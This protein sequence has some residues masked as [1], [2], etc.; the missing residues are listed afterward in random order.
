MC[1]L[2]PP[3]PAPHPP[4][5]LPTSSTKGFKPRVASFWEEKLE[6][7]PSI[8]SVAYVS[9]RGT[10]AESSPARKWRTE[11]E[12]FGNSDWTVRDGPSANKLLSTGEAGWSGLPPHTLQYSKMAHRMNTGLIVGYLRFKFIYMS[13]RFLFVLSFHIYSWRIFKQFSRTCCWTSF[14]DWPIAASLVYFSGYRRLKYLNI[15]I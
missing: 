12:D 6:K 5:P 13:F 10:V 9:R 7:C 8:L 4:T 1:R 2:P 14:S 15:K 3:L 11:S